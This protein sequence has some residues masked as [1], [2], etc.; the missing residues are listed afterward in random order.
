MDFQPH[1]NTEMIFD[2]DSHYEATVDTSQMHYYKKALRSFMIDWSTI[3]FSVSVF[4]NCDRMFDADYDLDLHTYAYISKVTK[5]L[6]GK[7]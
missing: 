2:Y 5:D 3:F 7:Q 4:C 6:Q 1:A